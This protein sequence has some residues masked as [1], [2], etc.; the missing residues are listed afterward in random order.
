MAQKTASTASTGFQPFCGDHEGELDYAKSIHNFSVPQPVADHTGIEDLSEY[1]GFEHRGHTFVTSS[2]IT[3]VRRGLRHEHCHAGTDTDPQSDLTQHAAIE[4]TVK[5]LAD[6]FDSWFEG[7]PGGHHDPTSDEAVSPE[8][9]YKFLMTKD[10]LNL[11][12]QD[13]VPYAREA[14][15]Q[16]IV[17]ALALLL[18]AVDSHKIADEAAQKEAA[19]ERLRHGLRI[20]YSTDLSRE[21]AIDVVNEAY[22]ELGR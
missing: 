21:E 9:L 11:R 10:P 19:K 13:R 12:Q 1:N 8:S 14:H 18:S 16:I 2:V 7:T 20:H 4:R 17:S 15:R 3:E 5:T 22:D 6:V